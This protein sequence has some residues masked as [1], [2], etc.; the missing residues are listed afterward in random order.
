MSDTCRSCSHSKD[1][2]SFGNKLRIS[3][4]QPIGEEAH[5]EQSLPIGKSFAENL[6]HS[7]NDLL[8]KFQTIS[9]KVFQKELA[10]EIPLSTIEGKSNLLGRLSDHD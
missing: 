3:L 6:L 1:C 4:L 8:R 10:R 9:A 2:S 7:L 5:G